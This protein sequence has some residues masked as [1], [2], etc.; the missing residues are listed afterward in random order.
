LLLGLLLAGGGGLPAPSSCPPPGATPPIPESLLDA[1]VFLIGDA[2][3]PDLDR[4]PLLVALGRALAAR[5][6]AVG[7]E[8]VLA[9]FLGDNV[10]P[11]G[12]P[13][14]GRNGFLRQRVK[15][16]AQLAVFGAP[17]SPG[18]RGVFVP[19]NHDWDRSGREGL[20]R[21]R[22]LGS[23]VGS[24]GRGRVEVLP[25]SGC[26]GP[27]VMDLGSRLRLIALDTQWWLH[28]HDKPRDPVSECEADSEEEVEAGLAAALAGAAGRHAVVVAHHP[29]ISGG[30]HGTLREGRLGQDPDQDLGSPA[31]RR[32][33]EA[34][35]LAL[36]G[37]PPLLVAGGH[38]HS[39]QLLRGPGF[40]F[41][42]VSG[43]GSK[44][45]RVRAL[46][47]TVFCQEAHGF[48]RLDVA[49]DGRARLAV[50]ALTGT[51]GE[52]TEAGSFEL[53]P[54]GPP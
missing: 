45:A 36:A 31:Y 20:L 17:G 47:E 10:Y 15:L 11:R 32:M 6:A 4:D 13:P 30:P 23:Y 21:V 9:V 18:P 54:A 14:A 41:Q 33:R 2:G 24:R 37:H 28:R 53:A 19:G 26:P 40:P 52:V 48:M 51:G 3:A 34:L 46:P 35:G 12:L 27:S 16:D 1:T 39:L 49:R 29:L 43:S 38:D 25:A 7:G 44:L 8:R 22:A 50:L 42:A 5:A